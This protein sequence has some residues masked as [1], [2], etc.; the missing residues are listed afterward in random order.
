MITFYLVRLHH[1]QLSVFLRSVIFD[2][3]FTQIPFLAL[4]CLFHLLL[5]L[6]LFHTSAQNIHTRRTGQVPAC[7][8]HV[9]ML[10][11]VQYLQLL[12][13][14]LVS[15]WILSWVLYRMGLLAIVRLGKGQLRLERIIPG[16]GLSGIFQLV[17]GIEVGFFR[18]PQVF[19]RIQRLIEHFL[20]V[21]FLILPT[22]VQIG[23]DFRQLDSF[24]I[25]P[26][27]SICNFI[28]ARLH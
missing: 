28:L 2:P 18:L 7:Q 10:N 14:Q 16:Q 11:H 15:V 24:I 23:L 1:E 21:P 9:C 6:L 12:I 4:H 3:H 5:L 22:H 27:A 8:L 19:L 20:S 13:R 17:Y 25:S 26:H